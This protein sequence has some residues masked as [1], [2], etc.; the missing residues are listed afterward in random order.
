MEG[1]KSCTYDRPTGTRSVNKRGPDKGVSILTSLC[2]NVPIFLAIPFHNSCHGLRTVL[3]SSIELILV[4]KGKL[5]PIGTPTT[6]LKQWKGE[7]MGGVWS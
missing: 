3:D 1:S 2:N 7:T 4:D 5:E 6:I